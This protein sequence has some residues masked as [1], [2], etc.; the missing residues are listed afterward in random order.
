MTNHGKKRKNIS[1]SLLNPLA[2]HKNLAKQKN[3]LSNSLSK[4]LAKFSNLLSRGSVHAYLHAGFHL[5]S[6]AR[7][8][9]LVF[10]CAH[11]QFRVW[12]FTAISKFLHQIGLPRA[13]TPQ[14]SRSSAAS[15]SWQS[16]AA[17]ACADH[18]ARVGRRADPLRPPLA[19]MAARRGD[20]RPPV[21]SGPPLT[22]SDGRRPARHGSFCG[23]ARRRMGGPHAAPVSI[24]CAGEQTWKTEKEDFGGKQTGELW[25][26]E[27]GSMWANC[28]VLA[29]QNGKLLKILYFFT[30]QIF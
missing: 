14:E 27:S 23:H 2:I 26:V 17:P 18:R 1:I 8:S 13:T 19:L 24:A 5:P 3:W 25:I 10:P 22:A 4:D 11:G 16:S 6:R 29:S 12:F 7:A 30:W 28:L 15:D 20:S 21:A 9:Q